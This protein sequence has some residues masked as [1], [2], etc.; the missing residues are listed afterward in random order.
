MTGTLSKTLRVRLHAKLHE[1]VGSIA[2]S[3]HCELLQNDSVLLVHIKANTDVPAE[4]EV[5][6]GKAKG[7]LCGE[8]LHALVGIPGPS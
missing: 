2:D 5:A 7:L 6:L 4:L 3:I 8:F 1:L